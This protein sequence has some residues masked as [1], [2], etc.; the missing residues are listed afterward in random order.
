MYEGNLVT[1][2]LKSTLNGRALPAQRIHECK[3]I[4]FDEEKDR[5]I[6]LLRSGELQELR[7]SSKYD[8]MIHMGREGLLCTGEVTRRYRGEKG[9]IVEFCI[10]NGFY[11]ININSVDK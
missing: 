5:M 8:C 1:L 11:K 3:V 7:L 2:E 6:L 9:N 4:E 10:E